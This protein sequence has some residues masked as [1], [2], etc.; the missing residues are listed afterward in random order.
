MRAL[1]L[2][3]F[4]AVTKGQSDW[5]AALASQQI[6]GVTCVLTSAD[7]SGT[8][9]NPLD[10]DTREAMLMP[11]LKRSG[12]PVQLVRA[13][14]VADSAA[15]VEHVL[16][17]IEAATGQW[18]TPLDTTLFSAN[19]D[20]RALFEAKGFETVGEQ[21]AGLTPQ[22]LVQ[23]V[24]E[25]KEWRS[26]ASPETEAVLARP[27]VQAKLK[28]IF[29]EKLVND[30]GELGHKRDFKSYGE[31][32]DAALRQKLDD[33]LPH[34]KP[35][36]IV[37]KGCGT[38]KLLVE[39]S[40]QFPESSFVGVDLSREFL[41]M[42][43]QNTYASEDISLVCGNI[44]DRNVEPGSATTVIFSSV[45][46]EI[47]S[48]TGY[49]LAELDR[50]LA[51]AASE[52]RAGGQVLIRDG[53]SPGVFLARLRF[54]KPATRE[55]FK[56]FASEF[57]RGQGVKHEWLGANEVRLTAHDANEFLCKK[58]YLK[59]WHIEIHEEYGAHTLDGYR[60]ALMRAGLTPVEVRG[61]VNGW[62]AAN[63]YQGSV[64][65]VDD[66]GKPLPWFDTNCVVVGRKP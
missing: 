43:D 26:F 16:A 61:Y 44:I 18:P 30:D 54:L 12:K 41:R 34:V 31:Q 17:K 23:R 45:T 56:R 57:K 33:L 14:D 59:N 52:L 55:V 50:A 37:D 1:L 15:W 66:T 65:L 13:S 27:V 47:Y 24:V 2:G 36:V 5:L 62:I 10:A 28:Q 40:R 29:G 21:I 49:S 11:A 60:A 8:R 46:H 58:D 3:R 53:V 32:M 63:R 39:L 22:E 9:R 42:C 38:G 6:E 64:E 19:R 4:H 7:L 48:Y 35:G 25:G 20:V 51:N